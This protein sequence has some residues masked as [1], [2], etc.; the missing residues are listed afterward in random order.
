[1][2]VVR[3]FVDEDFVLVAVL[4]DGRHVPIHLV[5][6]TDANGM[7][8]GDIALTDEGAEILAQHI[9]SAGLLDHPYVPSGSTLKN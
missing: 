9:A 4:A 8:V 6:A 2:K 1:M 5:D 7:A 3:A